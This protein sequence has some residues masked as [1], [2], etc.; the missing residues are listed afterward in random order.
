MSHTLHLTLNR[1]AQWIKDS[2]EKKKE[3]E[4]E[5]KVRREQRRAGPKHI[6]NDQE[7]MSQM[8]AN[9][10]NINDALK[11]G[12]ANYEYNFPYTYKSYTGLAA[13]SSSSGTSGIK[14]QCAA[15]EPSAAKKLHL[16]YANTN[17]T[18][19]IYMCIIGLVWM[20]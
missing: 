16:W 3:A 12:T 4:K 7:Y 20:T 11:Q 14:R 10:D 9:T 19:N 15:S 5:K 1:L 2:A 18:C 8:Q 13:C 6:F 17:T